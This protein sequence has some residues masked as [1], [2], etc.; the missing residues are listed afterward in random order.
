MNFIRK[1]SRKLFTNKYVDLCVISVVFISILLLAFETM[2]GF[3]LNKK[4]LDSLSTR[5]DPDKLEALE[6]LA[7]KKFSSDELTAIL[8][9]SW[10]KIDEEKD[11]YEI[12]KDT[13]ILINELKNDSAINLLKGNKFT[14]ELLRKKLKDLNFTLVGIEKILLNSTRSTEK[15]SDT[16]APNK[17]NFI[18]LLKFKEFREEDLKKLLH[19][20]AFNDVEINTVLSHTTKLHFNKN[21]IEVVLQESQL[22]FPITERTKMT[23]IGI[24][25]IILAFFIIEL[26]L[27]YFSCA[28]YKIFFSRY[29]VDIIAVVPLFRV[30]RLGRIFILLRLF[31]VMSFAVLLGRHMSFFTSVFNKRWIDL[32][33]ILIFLIFVITFGTFGLISSEPRLHPTPENCFWTVVYSFFFGQYYADFPDTLMG[34]VT[35]LIVVIA[36]MSVFAIMIGT[37]SAIMMEKFKEGIIMR[38]TSFD[39]LENHIIICGWEQKTLQIIKE[40]QASSEYKNSDIVLI[41]DRENFM[42]MDLQKPGIKTDRIYL[43]Q[44]DFTDPNILR[45][46][47]INT[48]KIAII[49]PDRTGERNNRDIDARTVLTALTIEKLNQTVYSCAELLDAEYESHM[50]MGN[51]NEV[52]LG[53][54]YSGLMAAHAAMNENIIPFIK[55]I[56]PS[57]SENKFQNIRLPEDL[58]GKE[59]GDVIE[60]LRKKQK[61]LPVGV[62]TAEGELIINPQNYIMK[63]GDY[64]IGLVSK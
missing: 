28:N 11:F 51:V 4:A 22:L 47:N 44:G 61:T 60:E 36:G 35:I 34:K 62:R 50:R 64:L 45:K 12:N 53:G 43:M 39:I 29:W 20:A 2:A 7:N 5:I 16:L 3:E 52:I 8:E 31:R 57:Q 15:L 46:A 63:K 59:F 42:N 32:F 9:E 49:L 54:Y 10:L 14:E 30:F 17:V 24:D 6:T 48:A 25:D 1:F 56:L 33:L 13:E 26:L 18:Q 23:I 27:R 58:I 21:E 19:Q 40:L 41:S 38:K 55:N 37:V